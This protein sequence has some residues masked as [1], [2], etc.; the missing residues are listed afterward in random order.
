MHISSVLANVL[1]FFTMREFR[2]VS[3]MDVLDEIP[4]ICRKVRKALHEIR[5]VIDALKD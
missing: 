5:K 4:L 3:L 2:K 1:L